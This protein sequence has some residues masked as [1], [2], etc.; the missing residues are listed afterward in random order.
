M[1]PPNGAFP[2]SRG[3]T[4]GGGL[5]PEPTRARAEN[6]H[7]PPPR[8]GNGGRAPGLADVSTELS[9]PHSE[10]PPALGNL[11][12]SREDEE[13]IPPPPM[14]A[15][16]VDAFSEFE[17]NLS[18]ESTRIEESDLIAEQSTAIIEESP[19][20]PFLFVE[21]GKDLGKEYALQEGETS[22]GRGIDNDVILSDVS[23]SRRHVR[24]QRQGG[25]FT[26][27][28]LGSGNGTQ[29]NGRRAHVEQLADGDRIELGETVLVL[30]IPGSDLPVTEIAAGQ[31]T[32]ETYAPVSGELQA[33]HAP[34]GA[35]SPQVNSLPPLVNTLPP[36]GASTD[37]LMAPRDGRTQSVVLPR[38]FLFIAAGAVAIV[39]SVIG[40]GVVTVMGREP[41]P[42]AT[43][44]P[45]RV[46]PAAVSPVA[47]PPTAVPP[48][49]VPAPVAGA[50]AAPVPVAPV[51]VAPVPVAPVVP[52]GVA[53][54]E[55]APAVATA[56]GT[57]PVAG[58]T[59]PAPAE[60]AA[61]APSGRSRDRGRAAAPAS[62]GRVT[63]IPRRGGTEAA[64]PPA[65]GAGRD[66]A[67]AAYRSSDFAGAARMARD[68]ARTASSRDRPALEHLASDI[69]TFAGYFRQI[70]S[71]GSNYASVARIGATAISL[72]Q[73]IGGGAH[74]RSFATGFAGW[75]LDRADGS[76]SRDPVAACSDGRTA[77]GI[78]ASA[79]ART[80]AT[81][82]EARATEMLAE[83]GR[84]ERSDPSRARDLYRSIVRLAPGSRSATDAQRRLDALGR[85]RSVDEDE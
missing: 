68:A 17:G 13:S 56:A 5:S 70:R 19:R 50:P 63:V 35:L 73:R 38:R 80:L 47:V 39:G 41:D 74:T 62:G 21:A 32:H 82:C 14:P 20:L 78:A 49:V 58:V 48:A 75:L 54:T 61:E 66:A 51:V 55:P 34:M 40:A 83:A 11:P 7:A 10:P 85:A 26:L 31:E 60:D 43:G 81:R 3:P 77:A 71:A 69:D 37:E 72:D 15:A 12:T 8:M 27:R 65:R 16:N 9:Q 57:P 64:S 29:L 4:G 44:L 59:E 45:V 52:T 22:I 24:V 46:A 30:R 2:G 23:V 6:E 79:R 1:A 28:D 53:P 42:V 76:F 67:I 25:Q 36:P 33:G 18:G 84:A